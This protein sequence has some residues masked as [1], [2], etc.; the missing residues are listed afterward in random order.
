MI[1]GVVVVATTCL[2]VYFVAEVGT[3][4]K[5]CMAEGSRAKIF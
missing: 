4:G 5:L 2:D 3:W 1:C